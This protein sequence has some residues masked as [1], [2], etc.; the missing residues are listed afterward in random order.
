VTRKSNCAYCGYYC[1]FDC[2]IEVEQDGH[3]RLVGLQPDTS[4]YPYAE[5]IF[6]S[7]RRW[8]L[9]LSDIDS[10]RRLNYPLK[11]IGATRG[12]LG[13]CGLEVGSKLALGADDGQWQRISWSQALAEIAQ[14]FDQ[15]RQRYGAATLA[16]AIGGPH[17]SFWPLHRL[18]TLFGSPNNMG[19]GQ[20]CWNIRILMD[21]Q[22]YG[23]PIEVEIDPQVSGQVLL[24]GTNPAV[25]DNSEFWRRILALRPAGVPLIVVD[26]RQTQ[27]AK[28]ADL[29]LQ[30]RPGSDVVLAL[31]LIRELLEQGLYDQSFVE[32]WCLGLAELRAMVAPYTL[33]RAS[34]LCDLPAAQIA[35]AARLI[36]H[37]PDAHPTA[38]LTGRGIDE[39]GPNTAPTHKAISILRALL[40]DVDKAGGCAIMDTS[41]FTEELDLEYSE[42]MSPEC[43]AAQLGHNSIQSY[44]GYEQMRTQTSKIEGKRLP[45]RYLTSAHP[46]LVWRAALG[47]GPYRVSAL[48]IEATNP[49]LTYADANLVE[50]AFAALDTI[51]CLEQRLSHSAQFA[52]YLLPAAG[53][54]ERP[55]WQMHGGVSNFCYGGARAVKPYYERKCDYEILRGLGLALGQSEADWP[56]VSLDEAIERALAPTGMSYQQWSE[57]GMYYGSGRYAKQELPDAQGSPRG[58]A[59]AS[60]KIEFTP[61]PQP[62][63]G[64]LGKLYPELEDSL[65]LFTGRAEDESCKEGLSEAGREA[66]PGLPGRPYILLTGARMQPFWASS[67]HDVPAFQAEHPQALVQMSAATLAEIGVA[68]GAQLRLSTAKGSAVFTTQVAAI[69]DGV[70][71]AEYGWPDP[72]NINRLTSADYED[73]EPQ[74]GSWIYDGLPVWVEPV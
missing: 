64:L 25:S 41:D 1:G 50:R 9:N 55:L 4:R 38:L 7:C 49:L 28:R 67:F 44:A 32:R 15:L 27:T 16:S 3:E 56:D 17:A 14:R 47:Q 40:G 65:G 61:L 8:R 48:L 42:R 12:Q 70:L 57:V 62:D 10:P 51:V 34:L 37:A 72:A 29:H 69:K 24:W 21:A 5:R 59:T 19:I 18:M 6:K 33:D 26:P 60:G 11:R 68:E 22:T 36:A 52:D 73:C 13:R 30:L 53:A 66:C 20:I 43:K 39:L 54:I 74:I 71:S 63:L 46:N 2:E 45:M 35:E 31:A 58:F 23:W